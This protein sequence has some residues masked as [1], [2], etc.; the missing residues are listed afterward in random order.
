[1]NTT[2]FSLMQPNQNGAQ[3]DESLQAYI[4]NNNARLAMTPKWDST[5]T[6]LTTPGGV[7]VNLL[8]FNNAVSVPGSVTGWNPG[9]TLS[10]TYSIQAG[11]GGPNG[12]YYYYITGV[13]STGLETACSPSEP[14]NPIV[15]GGAVASVTLLQVPT[16][17]DSRITARNIYRSK[18][19]T[20][21]TFD[22]L[23]KAPQ[24]VGTISDNSTSVF[25]DSVADGS[26]GVFAPFVDTTSQYFYQNTVF[27]GNVT[28]TA[29][30]FG[31][32]GPSSRNL[33]YY[34][35]GFGSNNLTNNAGGV[36]NTAIGGDCLLSNTTG[37]ANVGLGIHAGAGNTTG[38]NNISIGYTAA[39]Y[40]A[41][42]SQNI[43]I[44]TLALTNDTGSGS[45]TVVGYSAGVGQTTGNQ[46]TYFGYR[47]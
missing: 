8:N 44:G 7:A 18:S 21:D 13:I 47:A 31:I 33:G 26:L 10:T 36:R 34:C 25:V 42:G 5:G 6:A 16:F 14:A 40:N 37:S 30:Y 1:M 20:S 43:A 24:L 12:K 2:N 46:N 28:G 22:V 9:L 45:N 3:S 41:T 39:Q 38:N 17:A 19:A 15:T 4:A 27:L 32:G 23:A 11:T 35:F 29:N